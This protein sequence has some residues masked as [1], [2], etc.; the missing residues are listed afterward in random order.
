LWALL[1]VA[2]AVRLIEVLRNP[3]WFD[4]IYTLRQAQASWSGLWALL[5]QDI[6]PPLHALL[7]WAWVHLAGDGMPWLRTLPLVAGLLTIAAAH[8]FAR[9]A[10]GRPTSILAAGLLALHPA[11]VHLSQELRSFSLL[12]LLLL[13][14]T[15]MAWR[16]VGDGRRRDGVLYVLAAAAALYTHYLAGLALAVVGLWGLVALTRTPRRAAS[17]LG[18]NAAVLALFLP[19]VPALLAGFRLQQDHWIPTPDREALLRLARSQAFGHRVLIPVL[20]GLALL[21]WRHRR[22]RA[23]TALLWLTGPVMGLLAWSVALAGP[24]IFTERYLAFA[25]PSL[26]ILGAAGVTAVRWRILAWALALMMLAAAGRVLLLS[27]PHQEAVSL[28]RVSRVIA[29]AGGAGDIVFAGDTHSLLTLQYHL[30]PGVPVRL[31][32]RDDHLPYYEGSALIGGESRVRPEEVGAASAAGER[33]WAVRMPTA[34]TPTDWTVP[35]FDSLAA[36]H[37]RYGPV[38]VWFARPD[39]RPP[40]EGPPAAP[41]AAPGR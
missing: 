5:E 19:Q 8:A 41:R 2:A 39:M 22:A 3:L 10:Y 13:L 34:G 15:W 40:G 12:A 17:W 37:D 25:L 36:G 11:H 9:E 18:L 27:P 14:A 7:V 23:A 1:A 29:G 33:W 31:V 24:H 4:E 26:L 35:L 38:T 28:E 6:H 30:G 20:A 32:L 21:A 16:W